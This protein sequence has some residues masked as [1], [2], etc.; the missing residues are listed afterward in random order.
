MP[1]KAVQFFAQLFEQETGVAYHPRDHLQLRSRLEAFIEDEGI[2]TLEELKL[3]ISSQGWEPLKQKLVD[4]STDN[5]T[6]FFRNL[7]CFRAIEKVLS[8]PF[9]TQ[10]G[11]EIRVWCAGVST[12]Q[13]A[14][15][16]AM[17]LE[18][19]RVR[20]GFAN[21]VIVASDVCERALRRARLGLYSD[22]ESSDLEPHLRDRFFVP[23]AQGWEARDSLLRQVTYLKDNLLSPGIAG[24]FDLIL[25]RNVL[26][27]K[28][29]EHKKL[30]TRQLLERLT[31]NG[32][33][34]LGARET[35]LDVAP[36]LDTLMVG[37]VLFFRRKP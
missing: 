3:L 37:E 7:K 26:G 4:L 2:A 1:K 21:H 23:H 20:M 34:L 22:S 8:P 28:S 19:L 30:I 13:E 14:L 31:P 11:E 15:S 16:V 18:L 9:L 29:R 17:V 27:D 25:C 12:G 24:P 10:P 36:D 32:L 6:R 33:I 5:Q 35:L